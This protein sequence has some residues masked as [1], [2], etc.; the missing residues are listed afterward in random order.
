MNC[1]KSILLSLLLFPNCLFGQSITLQQKLFYTCKVWG[2]VKYYHSNVS[3]CHV[4]WDS[5]LLHSLPAIKAAGTID[6]FNNAL[7]TMLAAAGPMALATSYFPDVLPLELKRNRDWGWISSPLLRT[8]LQVQL[9]TIKNNFRPHAGCYVENN[10]GMIGASYS[11]WLILPH[12][13][14]EYTSHIATSL[15][16]ENNRLLI[17]FKYWNIIQYFNPYNY[18]LDQPWDSTLSNFVLKFDTASSPKSLYWSILRMTT[19]L[20]DAH[21]YG[22]TYSYY[23]TNPLEF[24]KPKIRMQYISGQYVVTRSMVAT[25]NRG[26]VVLAVNGLTPSQ[27][28]DSLI[29]FYSAGNIAQLRRD[30]C[31]NMLG[32]TAPGMIDTIVVL[33]NFGIAHTDTAIC[34]YNL[35]TAYFYQDAFYPNDTLDSLRW[36]V[37]PCDIGY[38]NMGN[39]YDSNIN[40]MWVDLQNKSAIIFDLRNYPSNNIYSLA[41]VLFP[42]NMIVSKFLEPDVTY[43]GTFFWAYGSMGLSSNPTP[44][45]G[46]VIILVNEQ[47]QSAAEFSAMALRKMA[48]SVVVGSQ[49]AGADG[50]V[51]YWNI[52]PDITTGFTSLGV[53]YPNGDSTQRI[54]IVPDSV[55]YPTKEAIRARRDLVL[56][57]ALE[58]GGCTLSASKLHKTNV[59]VHIYPN[60]VNNELN[61]DITNNNGLNTSL[62]VTDIVSRVLKSTMV[63]GAMATTHNT[64]DISTLAQGVYF[65]EVLTDNGKLVNKFVKQ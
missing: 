37:M 49:T 53:F 56:E 19:N 29:H 60:P 25:I 6:S 65:L 7:D 44:Y 4:N 2:F 51:T 21:A 47:T 9:D 36:T 35:A 31:G 18:V 11:G 41:N 58:I 59:A 48:N 54:G 62:Q 50:N 22:E 23:I 15:P 13:D 17:L 45:T 42:N 43:P 1:V 57:K 5:V 39:L 33:D 8:D 20:N 16:N 3:V 40:E 26:D 55:V 52:S 32:K 30:V 61:I 12:D 28:E 64:I 46:K 63:D 10:P 34:N 38:V 27:W 24:F 14:T